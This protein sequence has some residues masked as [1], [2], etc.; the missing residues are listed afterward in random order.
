MKIKILLWGG[1][2][3]LLG[4]VMGHGATRQGWE[5]GMA[6]LASLLSCVLIHVMSDALKRRELE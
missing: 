6:I 1:T 2:L 3:S 5:L 4:S